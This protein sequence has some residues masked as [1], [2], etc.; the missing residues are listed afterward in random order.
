MRKH[1]SI[2]LLALVSTGVACQGADMTMVQTDEATSDIGKTEQGLVLTPAGIYEEK[3]FFDAGPNAG[4]PFAAMILWQGPTLKF[5]LAGS[6]VGELSYDPTLPD[7][8]GPGSTAFYDY[9]NDG[10]GCTSAISV[11]LGVS[12]RTCSMT[13]NL[14]FVGV[15]GS[16]TFPLAVSY[17]T[18]IGVASQPQ[19][20]AG[21]THD[22]TGGGAV[23]HF[24]KADPVRCE[25]FRVKIAAFLAGKGTGILTPPSLCL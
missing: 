5:A 4:Q 18:N 23:A 14:F 8:S 9:A 3:G 1:I 10:S 16:F 20:D 13:E 22:S 25:A 6:N 15:P 17:T 19:T 7:G 21:Q 11:P 24:V 2:A 12:K